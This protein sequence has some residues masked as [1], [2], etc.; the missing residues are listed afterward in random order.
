MSTD[1]HPRHLHTSSLHTRSLISAPVDIHPEHLP[2]VPLDG[3]AGAGAGGPQA[4]DEGAGAG[5]VRQSH[6]LIRAVG[7][8]LFQCLSN[9]SRPEN[10]NTVHSE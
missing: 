9:G 8:C 10:D 3:V 2:Q 7:L 4:Q 6:S 5:S 1:H